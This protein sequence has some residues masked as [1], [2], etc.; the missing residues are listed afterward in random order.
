MPAHRL[1]RFLTYDQLAEAL[2]LSLG[3]LKN[4]VSQG[5]IPHTKLGRNVRFDPDAIEN[6]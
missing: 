6:G 2:Q 4:W 3:T 5:F 1:D